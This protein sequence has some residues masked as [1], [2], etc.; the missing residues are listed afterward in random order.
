MTALIAVTAVTKR[1]PGVT[2][3]EDVSLEVG[4]GEVHALLGHNGAGKSTLIRLIS[5]EQ[6]P[7]EGGLVVEGVPVELGSPADALA[8]GIAVVSQERTL[9]PSLSVAENVLLNRLPRRRGSVD[10]TA[11][12]AKA[13]EALDLLDVR[14]DTRASVESLSSAEQTVVEIARALSQQVHLLVLDEPTAS[15]SGHETERLFDVMRGLTRQGYGVILVSHRIPDVLAIAD[16]VMVLR[17]GKVCYA[18]RVSAGLGPTLV[19]EM[20]GST[21]HPAVTTRA[22]DSVVESSFDL[23]ATGVSVAGVLEPLD[24]TVRS[25]ETVGLFGLVGSGAIEVPYAL[26]GA[27]SHGGTVTMNGIQVRTPAQAARLG[28]AFIPA[29]RAN[30]ILPQADVQRNFGIASLAAYRRRGVFQRSAERAAATGWV[31][32]LEVVSRGLRSLVT[33]LSG[34]NQQKLILARWLTRQVKVLLLAEPTLGV[35]VGSRAAVHEIIRQAASA[36]SA[37]VMASTD[38]DEILEVSD[39]IV[40]MNAGRVVGTFDAGDPSARTQV[41]AT[42]SGDSP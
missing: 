21:E 14:I 29:E 36:G 7:D 4:K 32:R 34:G 40:V 17:D 2:A 16:A 24:L 26:F 8:R 1:Y 20:I 30:A 37:V 10:W 23:V 9:V 3:L 22:A 25:G 6:Q 28:V 42:A 13:S 12:H 15:L 35:D 5:G 11:A 31:D 39:R 27:V 33:G 41:V 38:I 18:G 19:R